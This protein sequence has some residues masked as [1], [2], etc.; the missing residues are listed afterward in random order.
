MHA[1]IET[2]I[3]RPAYAWIAVALQLLTAVAAIPVGLEMVRNPEGAPLGLPQAWID[4]TVFGSY[5]L[6]G[7]FLFAINGIGQLVAAAAIVLRNAAAPWLTGVLGVG[8]M[9]WIAVQVAMMPF[10][11]LQPIIFV[12][13]LIEAVVAAAWLRRQR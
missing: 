1:V 11:P 2:R 9:I 4:A 5:L 7:L 8:L 10:H 13:G 3:E 6:P 12:V